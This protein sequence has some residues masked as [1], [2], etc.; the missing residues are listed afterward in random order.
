[1]EKNTPSHQPLW[2]FDQVQGQ[3][4]VTNQIDSYTTPYYTKIAY[5]K[6]MLKS[7]NK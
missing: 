5:P 4:T 7:Y 6:S 3:H 1:M 2:T